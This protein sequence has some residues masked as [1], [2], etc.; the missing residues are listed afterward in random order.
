MHTF[1]PDIT[2]HHTASHCI[3]LQSLSLGECSGILLYGDTVQL[4][5]RL[6]QT[7]SDTPPATK[8]SGAELWLGSS[9]VLS[10]LRISSAVCI[11]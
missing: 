8:L 11:S 1:D 2:L 4:T 3:L 6:T 5:E 7:L 9:K 10:W